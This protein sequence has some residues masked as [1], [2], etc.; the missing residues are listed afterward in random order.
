MHTNSWSKKLYTLLPAVRYFLT[1]AGILAAL[2]KQPISA[3]LF[4]ALNPHPP[5]P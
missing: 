2:A 5:S 1:A 3:G 4:K